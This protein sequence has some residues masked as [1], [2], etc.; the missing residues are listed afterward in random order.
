LLED[1]Q[2]SSLVVFHSMLTARHDAGL[3]TNPQKDPNCR[4]RTEVHAGQG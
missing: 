2:L 1:K 3:I 4:Q